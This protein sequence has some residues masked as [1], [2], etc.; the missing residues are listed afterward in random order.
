MTDFLNGAFGPLSPIPPM[1]IDTPEDSGRAGPRRYQYPI[2]WNLPVGQPGTEGGFKLAPFSVLYKYADMY[3]VGRTCINI[4]RD[5]MAGLSWDIGPTADAQAV[6]KGDK[7]AVKDLRERAQKI[8]KWFKHLDSNYYGFQNWF[9]AALEQQIVI[10]ALSLY[11]A[12]TRV[13]GKGLFGSDLSELQL[14]D[15]ASIRPLYDLSGAKPR[16]PAPAYQQ[17]LWGVPRS[18]YQAIM[19]DADLETMKEDLAAAGVKEDLEPVKEYR[20]DQLLYMPRLPRINSPYGFGPVEQA[21]IPFTL[22][23]LRQNYLLDFYGEG[24]IP[25][26]FVIAGTQYVT[27]A[28]QR[29]LQDTLN[30]IAGD[31]AWKHRIIVLPPGSSSEP[32]KNMDGQWQI[33]QMIAEQVAMIMHIQPHEIGM[34]PGGKSGGL[35]GGKGVAE[36]QNASV[37][38]QRTEPDRNWWKESCFDLI[39]QTV[40]KQEDLEWKW[41]DFEE[42]EDDEKKATTQ[43]TLIFSGQSTIDQERIENGDDAYGFPLTQSPFIMVGSQIISLDPNVPSPPPPAAPGGL[44]GGAPAGGPAGQALTAALQPDLGKNPDKPKHNPAA[45]LLSDKKKDRKKGRHELADRFADN[46]KDVTKHPPTDGAAPG[47][48]PAVPGTATQPSVPVATGTQTPAVAPV[49]PAKPKKKLADLGWDSAAK[50]AADQAF[51]DQLTVADLVKAHVK[52]KGDL[53]KIVYTYLLRSY[54]EKAVEWVK[55]GNW[56]YDPKVKL[57]DINMARRPGGRNPQKVN[58]ISGSL[59]QGASMDPLVLIERQ[60]QSEYKY[61]IADGWHRTL[62]AKDAGWD[63]VPAFIGT[64]MDD[65]ADWGLQMQDESD[66]IK[67]AQM[68]ELAVISRFLRKRGTIAR[69]KPAAL[70]PIQ[71]RLLTADLERMERA[72]ALDAARDRIKSFGLSAPLA[73]GIAPFDLDGQNPLDFD[74]TGSQG[75]GRRCPRCNSPMTKFERGPDCT[76][77]RVGELAP[78][79][80]YSDDEARDDHGQWTSGGSDAGQAL[81]DPGRAGEGLGTR[82]DSMDIFHDYPNP[83]Q[84]VNRPIKE[85]L[86]DLFAPSRNLGGPGTQL[87]IDAARWD[88]DIFRELIHPTLDRPLPGPIQGW[89]DPQKQKIV[90]A[91]L[92]AVE[93]ELHKR[94]INP[95]TVSDDSATLTKY[96]PDQPRDDHGRFGT[97]DGSPSVG[98]MRDALRENGGFTLNVRTGQPPTAGYVVALQGHSGIMK[99]A[100]FMTDNKAARDFVKGWLK[101]KSSQLTK[102]GWVG[103]WLDTAHNEVVLDPVENPQGLD[104]AIQLGQ[105]RNQQSIWDVVNMTEIPTGGTGDRPEG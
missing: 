51:T 87:A 57:S 32:Q 55:T 5:E 59:K 88:A 21:L 97:G 31:Q 99:S 85:I 4:R 92:G 95:L 75:E 86:S 47:S 19:T 79:D 36:Q 27:P 56:E 10:D 12:P 65:T 11:L 35:S 30:A 69:F 96:S 81:P 94:G 16:P 44:P 14:L 83:K 26:T 84:F 6:S 89:T 100:K 76:N 22:G 23:M 42:E 67:K 103:G 50:I 77:C 66:S 91:L 2:G 3:S 101:D 48:K 9:T 73:T 24:S 34:L 43:Q 98:S 53:A 102:A 54:P 61:D 63:E 105:D 72:S 1:P 45:A 90:T 25:G 68:A 70:D 15:G 74:M 52:Y 18:E 60:D 80:K 28:Q 13:E 71:M 29:Q 78:V 58:D 8:V 41:L 7:G 20:G 49:A 33:D 40:F 82:D 93:K 104:Q 46:L 62:G 17:Y 64:G 37:T 38:E 39:I